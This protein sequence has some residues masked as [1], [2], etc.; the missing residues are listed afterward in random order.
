MALYRQEGPILNNKQIIGGLVVLVTVAVATILVINRDRIGCIVVANR[1][2]ERFV[3]NLTDSG[4]D[5][6]VS[7]K[8][9]RLAYLSSC[10]IENGI[11]P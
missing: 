9:A 8:E 11:T 2:A 4:T 5:D 10:Y 1:A 6:V 3:A 7:K